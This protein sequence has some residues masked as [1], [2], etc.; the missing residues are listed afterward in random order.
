ML[1][2]S[3]LPKTLWAEAAATAN[4]LRNRIANQ[5]TILTPYEK[6]FGSK[7]NVSHFKVWGCKVWR[8]IDKQMRGKLDPKAELGFFVGYAEESGPRAYRVYNPQTRKVDIANNVMFDEQTSNSQTSNPPRTL[9]RD[10]NEDEEALARDQPTQSTPL[11]QNEDEGDARDQLTQPTQPHQIEDEEAQADQPMLLIQPTQDE[12]D[13]ADQNEEE[14]T[15]VD[16]PI[17]RRSNRVPKPT[18]KPEFVYNEM[19]GSSHLAMSS[20]QMMDPCVPS[21][22]KEALAGPYANEWKAAMNAE[23][24]S[25]KQHGVFSPA[26]SPPGFCNTLKGLS[27]HRT[28]LS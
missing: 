4:Y 15:R 26:K 2:E 5:K 18:Q 16:Q 6:L 13:E 12:E 7:P 25:I 27:C 19:R 8:L 23:Y 20:V 10:Q 11:D 14:G 21:N 22:E 24:S 3:G 28:E 1:S 9:F 17:L